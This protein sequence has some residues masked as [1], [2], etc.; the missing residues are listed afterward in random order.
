[1][2]P[3]Y[4]REP[5]VCHV[6]LGCRTR[7]PL[8]G[9]VPS[10]SSLRPV[11]TPPRA[12]AHLGCGRAVL[13]EEFDELVAQDHR[14]P[15]APRVHELHAQRA[16]DRQAVDDVA[17]EVGALHELEDALVEHVTCPEVGPKIELAVSPRRARRGQ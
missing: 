7:L 17:E 15:L 13:S 16:D 9:A 14:E 3:L 2:T 4:G 11:A 8:C 6:P 10:V 5:R 12:R 1:M